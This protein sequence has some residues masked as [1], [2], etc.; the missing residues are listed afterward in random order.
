[1]VFF[2]TTW[3]PRWRACTKPNLSETRIISRPDIWGRSGMNCHIKRRQK[4]TG[5]FMKR[6]LFQIEFCCLCEILY[7]FFNG[8]SLADRSHFGTIGYIP[9]LFFV[10]HGGKSSR[11]IRSL[12]QYNIIHPKKSTVF[13]LAEG[14]IRSANEE[15]TNGRIDKNLR[16]SGNKVQT[17]SLD[18]GKKSASGGRT[19]P[20]MEKKNRE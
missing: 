18:T 9:I 14:G 13:F 16:L 3:L 4:C 8:S 20:A 11:H 1:M 10:D 7:S 19:R 17:A 12:C 6:K 2:I 5:A 15:E